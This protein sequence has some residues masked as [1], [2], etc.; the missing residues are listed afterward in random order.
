MSLVSSHT[1]IW[2][3]S[4]PTE[5]MFLKFHSFCPGNHC[6]STFD[7][8]QNRES[9]LMR[10]CPKAKTSPAFLKRVTCFCSNWRTPQI[11]NY[12]LNI[13]NHLPLEVAITG[14]YLISRFS[15]LTGAFKFFLHPGCFCLAVIV[16]MQP[17]YAL[18]QCL[19]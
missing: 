4:S 8:R 7:G 10:L 11:T 9:L 18:P 6:S 17:A 14:L 16:I 3:I 13:F 15:C 2:R 12:F 19:C 5:S 1:L